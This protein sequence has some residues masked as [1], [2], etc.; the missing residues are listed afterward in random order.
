MPGT[1]KSVLHH[2]HEGT[3]VKHEDGD[4]QDVSD[5][6]NQAQQKK[7]ELAEKAKVIFVFEEERDKD[8]STQ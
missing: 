4:V 8:K 5:I 1:D 7:D 3:A 6:A 2:P